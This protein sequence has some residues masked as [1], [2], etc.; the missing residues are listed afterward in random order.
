MAIKKSQVEDVAHLARLTIGEHDVEATTDTISRILTLVDQMKGVNTDDTPPMA[1]PM[2]AKQRLRAD[3][4]TE[5]DLREQLQR[6]APA[7]EEGLF[8][9]PR[10]IE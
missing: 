10:V 5:P 1:H 7:V 4:I 8:L 3:E 2:D 9:V 6:C